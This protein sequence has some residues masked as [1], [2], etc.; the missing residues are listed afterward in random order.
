MRGAAFRRVMTQR[1]ID[2]TVH[3]GKEAFCAFRSAAFLA[4]S[5]CRPDD[6]LWKVRRSFGL[7][8]LAFVKWKG[9]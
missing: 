1:P 3:G 9:L 8:G 5:E 6:G 7:P 2:T 4:A